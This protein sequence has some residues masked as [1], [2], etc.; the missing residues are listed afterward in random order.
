MHRM[1]CRRK[2][3]TGKVPERDMVVTETMV[4]LN[5]DNN[6]QYHTVAAMCG[7]C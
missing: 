2:G 3:R 7:Q 1:M 5:K 4:E 6:I